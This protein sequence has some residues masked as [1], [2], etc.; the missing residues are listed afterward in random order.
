MAEAKTKPIKGG[1]AAY[2][3]A[4][5]DPQRKRDTRTL[6]AL[7]RH[8]TGATPILW[9]SSI[10]GFGVHEYPSAK[11][12]SA[13]WPLLAFAL[14]SKGFVLYL[15]LGSGAHRD[16]LQALGTCKVS[17]GCLHIR[18]I[19]DVNLPILNRLLA[20]SAERI[21]AKVTR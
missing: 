21:R 16:L 5:D 20:Q 4:I 9:G 17:G 13:P 3:K 19:S 11:G 6:I 2:L 10:L 7:M 12:K 18:Q 14:R 15:G 8:A 1:V